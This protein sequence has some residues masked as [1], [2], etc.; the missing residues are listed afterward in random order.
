MDAFSISDFVVRIALAV[1]FNK[2]SVSS[3]NLTLNGTFLTS[4][5]N[6]TKCITTEV[7]SQEKLEKVPFYGFRGFKFT[8]NLN[9][10][11]VTINPQ[12]PYRV[13]AGGKRTGIERIEDIAAK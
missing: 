6:N 7:F 12:R 8:S 4:P 3:S 13:A 11:F 5:Y 2:A 10:K 9:R 1:L